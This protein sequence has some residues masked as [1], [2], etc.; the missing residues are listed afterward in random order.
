MT[1][2]HGIGNAIMDLQV[3]GTE[4]DLNHFDLE[5]ASM[6]LADTEL[7]TKVIQKLTDSNIHRTSGGSA[8]NT[9]IALAQLGI[10][11]SYSCVVGD[12][13][14]GKEYLAEMKEIGVE[15]SSR[16][17]EA[18]KT[19]TCVVIITPDAERTMVTNLGASALFSAED[20]DEECIKSSN[21]VYIEGYLFSSE[22]G[23]ESIEKTIALAKA[24]DTK[25]A[26]TFSDGFIVDVF[27]EPL[28]KAVAQADLIFANLNE[29]QA[30]T[31][32]QQEDEVFG[33]LKE[34]A[35]HVVMTKGA[36]GA[37]IYYEG[38]E[39]HIDAVPA[40]A[41]D[42]TGAGDIFAGA[43]LYGINR[44]KSGTAAGALACELASRIVSQLGPRLSG[45][46]KTPADALLM[47]A[48]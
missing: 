39:S 35:P 17:Q 37:R 18:D 13:Q 12:D 43:F 40:E 29:A 36:D 24:H 20:I 3:H 41:V 22:T 6:T 19:G 25:I 21:W 16:V 28:K 45:D 1:K 23:Q 11:C 47:R 4:E 2:I 30:F 26:I 34:A 48:G 15:L 8:A 9:M 10:P 31:G 42:D 5:K 46:I 14:F 33:A 7:Q 32:K 38:E 44:G 27:G